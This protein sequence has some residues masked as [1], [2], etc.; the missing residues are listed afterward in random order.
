MEKFHLDVYM[1]QSEKNYFSEDDPIIVPES[2]YAATKQSNEMVANIYSK[3]YK[4][5]I[6]GLRFFT[7]SNYLG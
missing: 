1:T 5:N 6:V 3:L 7:V 4:M 2:L